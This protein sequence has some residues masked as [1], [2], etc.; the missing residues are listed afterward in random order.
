MTFVARSPEELL[1]QVAF[2]RESLQTRPESPIPD[3]ASP[4]L[5]PALRDRVFYAPDP[6]GPGGKV[7]FVFPGSGNHFPGMGRDL[8]A[9]WPD[10][11]R[12]QQAENRRLRSQY[13]PD[14][15]W[16]DAV[17]GRHDREAVPLRP[18]GA[19]AR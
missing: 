5:R 13:A 17:A 10:V 18:G 11:L 19:R 9:H 8:S 7:A 15:F 14:K 16:A 6:L 3:P 4:D 1:E 2:A 12:R